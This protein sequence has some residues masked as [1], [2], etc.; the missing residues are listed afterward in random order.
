[1]AALFL[2]SIVS[3]MLFPGLEGSSMYIGELCRGGSCPDAKFPILDFDQGRGECV[4]RANPCWED[5]GVSHYCMA[6]TGFPYL[7]FSFSENKS[8]ECSCNTVP[9]YDSVHLSRELCPGHYCDSADFPILDWNP[10]QAK[11][12]CRGNPCLDE[13]GVVYKCKDPQLPIPHYFEDFNAEGGAVPKCECVARHEKP[14]SGLRGSFPRDSIRSC[15]FSK[16]SQQW[17]G[18]MAAI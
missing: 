14:N 6:S 18:G 12:F 3:M 4:C 15:K 13:D 17:K 2:I 7:H 10:E 16:S 8:L 5:N 11:C 9:Q 1:M